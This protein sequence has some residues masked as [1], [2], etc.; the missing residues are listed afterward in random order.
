MLLAMA[1]KP[2]RTMTKLLRPRFRVLC[3]KDIALGPGKVEL[4]AAIH[5]TGSINEAARHMGM[6]YMRAWTLIKTMQRCFK[7]PL[8]SALRGGKTGGGAQLT[9]TGRQALALYRQMQQESLA[10]SRNTWRQIQKLLLD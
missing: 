8:V 6:S 10:A 1:A 7:E 3:G 4:L 9:G 5:Q 2:K